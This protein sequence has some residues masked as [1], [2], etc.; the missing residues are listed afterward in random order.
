MNAAAVQ[1]F[2]ERFTSLSGTV[3]AVAGVDAAVSA[4]A[5]V[6]A[7]EA[8]ERVVV[9]GLPGELHAAIARHCQDAGIAFLEPPFAPGT[10]PGAIDACGVGISGC[11]F[12]IAETGTLVELATDDAHRL[13]STLPR[14]H[15]GVVDAAQCLPALLDAAPRL[16]DA[17]ANG[18]APCVATFLSGPSRTGDIE[19][20]LT[21]G[22]HGP[23]VA[24]ALIL[25][26]AGS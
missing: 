14:V 9:Y 5:R 11:A 15:I 13:V 21:L 2:T 18:G 10:L 12:A 16:R 22:V 3:H 4:I 20:R 8:A 7:D 24:H 26:G 1:L 17:F 19:M 6:L 23:A 25:G